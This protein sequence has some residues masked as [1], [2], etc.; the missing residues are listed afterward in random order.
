MIS[1]D[2][3]GIK[4][5]DVHHHT[6][7]LRIFFFQRIIKCFITLKTPLARDHAEHHFPCRGTAQIEVTDAAAVL[8]RIDKRGT[9]A[10]ERV[11]VR[12]DVVEDIRREPT[13]QTVHDM[14][15]VAG[16]VPHHD[17]AVTV[18]SDGDHRLVAIA[19]NIL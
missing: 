2:N 9:T 3:V 8:R 19:V 6:F 14:V 15:A 11:N 1:E 10:E 13:A 16:V 18:K 4:R 12:D 7:D 5:I 17:L